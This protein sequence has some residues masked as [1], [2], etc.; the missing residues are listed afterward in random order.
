MV[1][2]LIR[3]LRGIVHYLSTTLWFTA[4]WLPG[5]FALHFELYEGYF[6]FNF[7]YMKML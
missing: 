6:H 7:S 3:C 2:L 1:N 5:L 4:L